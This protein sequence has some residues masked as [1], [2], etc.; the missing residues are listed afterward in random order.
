MKY[1][2]LSL[3]THRIFK[4]L[5]IYIAE[6]IA[7]DKDALEGTE[8]VLS[9]IITGLSDKATVIWTK[10]DQTQEGTTESTRKAISSLT[11]SIIVR[12]E[13]QPSFLV[14]GV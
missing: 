1:C 13:S 10:G 6:V 4:K 11:I 2:N 3:L 8:N 9:C 14:L 12:P 5:T 7:T